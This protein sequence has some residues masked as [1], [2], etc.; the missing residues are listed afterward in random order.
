M[1]K[2]AG[3]RSKMAEDAA[4]EQRLCD[5]FHVQMQ[6]CLAARNHQEK[7]VH[8]LRTS[9]HARTPAE[10]RT[11]PAITLA[12]GA[13][14][15]SRRGGSALKS[16][17]HST[18]GLWTAATA[19]CRRLDR[20]WTRPSTTSK[21]GLSSSVCARLLSMAVHL[22]ERVQASAAGSPPGRPR[23][24]RSP[25]SGVAPRYGGGAEVRPAALL[26]RTSAATMKRRRQRR[27]S[28]RH[29]AAASRMHLTPDTGATTL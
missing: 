18:A 12:G 13:R 21:G 5:T 27:R 3:R 10:R 19:L 15:T 17:E 20:S 11:G 9:N 22:L 6:R 23:S 4:P 24:P 25:H 14:R 2:G 8:A 1:Y 26:W 7:R 29:S 16:R 28:E